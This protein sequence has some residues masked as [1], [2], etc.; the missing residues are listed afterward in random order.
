MTFKD[1][2]LRVVPAVPGGTCEVADVKKSL[3]RLQPHLNTKATVRVPIK[4][5]TAA[6][7]TV[8]AESVVTNL[9]ERAGNAVSVQAG[10]DTVMIPAATVLSWLDFS[11]VDGQLKPQMNSSR[12]SDYLAKNVTPKVSMPAGVSKVTTRDFVEIAR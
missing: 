9:R 10:G 1:E 12:A 4:E 3:A 7:T 2:Q 5:I 6:V 8:D 11:I